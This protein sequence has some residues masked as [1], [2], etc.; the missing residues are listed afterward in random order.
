MLNKSPPL[1]RDGAEVFL[2]LPR[3]ERVWHRLLQGILS[4]T[5]SYHRHARARPNTRCF[6]VQLKQLDSIPYWSVTNAEQTCIG[7]Q[8]VLHIAY[9]S[10]LLY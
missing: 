4:P 5:M 1:R 7:L 10:E 8:A 6:R 9:Y 3:A 2:Q